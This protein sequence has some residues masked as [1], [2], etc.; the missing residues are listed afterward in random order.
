VHFVYDF[1]QFSHKS[2]VFRSGMH[3]NCAI[4]LEKGR[5]ACR[6]K[7]SFPLSAI[8]FQLVRSPES[9]DLGCTCKIKR[10]AER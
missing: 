4:G 10:K 7:G 6:A 3:G 2:R 9:A 1:A 5:A 8:S